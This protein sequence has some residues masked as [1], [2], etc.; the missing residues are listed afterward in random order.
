M[1]EN[2]ISIDSTEIAEPAETA[3]EETSVHNSEGAFSEMENVSEKA[4]ETSAEATIDED[5]EM[6]TLT[7]Y[8][9]TVTV[10]K[11]EAVSAAQ[12]GMAFDSMKQ[13]LAAAKSDARIR[14][15]D[16]L[17]QMNG[18]SISQ[19]LGDMTSQSLTQQ[20]CDKYGNL[21]NVP[22]EELEDAMHKV[23][24]IRK[25]ADEAAAQ[26]VLTE[27]RSQLEE[28]LHHNPGCRDIP[29]EVIERAREGENLTLA[30][31][32][33]QNRQLAQQLEQ[34]QKELSVLKSGKQAKEKSMPSSK[35]TAADSGT[36]SIYGMMKSL[37]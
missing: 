14:A 4:A 24:D 30:Y 27:K 25:N 35:S 3:A 8:G 9:E 16:N 19:L 20:L 2:T 11:S 34:A 10:P 28:F 22:F 17:A 18:K 37:W 21:E 13:K 32:Q 23:Q 29:D 26:W 1:I 5:E 36:K 15:L 33:Y 12:K 7:V 31:S 6:L